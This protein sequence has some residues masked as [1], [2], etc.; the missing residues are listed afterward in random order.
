MGMV[1]ARRGLLLVQPSC[2]GRVSN[3]LALQIS[4]MNLPGRFVPWT[5]QPVFA[6]S[7]DVMVGVLGGG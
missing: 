4:K 7:L 1:F 3:P 6:N 2:L 5:V